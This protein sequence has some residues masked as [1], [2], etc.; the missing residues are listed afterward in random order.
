VAARRAYNDKTWQALVILQ[1]VLEYPL[2]YAL[3]G[4][5]KGEVHDP[6]DNVEISITN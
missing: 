4:F 1:G 2:K 3:V 6:G 5:R